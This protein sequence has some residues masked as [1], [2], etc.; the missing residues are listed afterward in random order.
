[1]HKTYSFIIVVMLMA[2]Y[3]NAQDVL[4]GTVYQDN[5]SVRLPNVFIKD[6]NNKQITI[7]DKRGNF[8]IRTAPGHILVFNSPGYVNDTLYV[9]DMI[10]KTVM[11]ASQFIALR[12]VDI[13]ASRKEFNPRLEYPEVYEKSK[14]YAFSPSTWFSKEGRDARRLKRY[15]RR[16][17]EER[18]IDYVF[19]KAYVSS[20][21]PLRGKELED[22][23]SLYRPSYSFLISNDKQSLVAYINDSYKK[24][25]A[26]PPDKRKLQPLT[27]DKTINDTTL[28]K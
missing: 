20:I 26:L 1:M 23:M 4:K 28:H 8:N 11:L 9:V 16:E 2:S 7:T 24:F 6:V 14:I 5:T 18:H 25:K 27:S 15:F 3:V 22:F 17:A 10:P 19:N 12:Q 21:V 13:T